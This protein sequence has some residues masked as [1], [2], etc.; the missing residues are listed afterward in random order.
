[1]LGERPFPNRLSETSAWAR[2]LWSGESWFA[3]GRLRLEPRRAF[4]LS[5]VAVGQH[6]PAAHRATCS[7][8]GEFPSL[9]LRIPETGGP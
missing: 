8:A 4:Q 1:M 7:P 9:R 2:G 6:M 3:F 5:A